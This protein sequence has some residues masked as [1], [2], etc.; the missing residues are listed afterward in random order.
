MPDA[1]PPFDADTTAR[2]IATQLGLVLPD[3]CVPGVRQNLAVLAEH[4]ASLRAALDP[5]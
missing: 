5:A 4:W 1:D 2:L 3:A